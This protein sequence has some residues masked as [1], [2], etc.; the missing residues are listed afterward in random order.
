MLTFE[1]LP[2]LFAEQNTYTT[3]IDRHAIAD[4]LAI[5]FAQLTLEQFTAM[6]VN[7]VS[8]SMAY[9]NLFSGAQDGQNIS[10]LFN[11]HR[12]DTKTRSSPRSI[13]AA[14]QQ[15]A[16]CHGLAR[17]CLFKRG[18]VNDLLH[19]VLQLGI[20]GI[21]YVN[22]F[23][24]HK[25]R[26]IYK[27]YLRP[28]DTHVLDPCAGWGGRLLGA[29]CCVPRYDGFE[30]A[31]RTFAG[32][33][34]L[35]TFISSMHPSFTANLSMV[36]FED[37]KLD[38][39]SYDMAFTSP[40]YYDTEEYSDEPTQSRIRYTTPYAWRDG[41][42]VALIQKTMRALRPGGR[43][44]LNIGSKTYPLATW[45]QEIATPTYRLTLLP[46]WM[47]GNAGFGKEANGEQFFLLEHW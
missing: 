47:S 45:L 21:Q 33:E 43:F 38:D 39:Q 4:A 2:D 28:T 18:K 5:Q 37:A 20:N 6:L 40:P 16:F 30:P 41:F 15:P 35:A 12:L 27:E 24:A 32:L 17:A 19:Q 13:F 3:R 10:L 7:P 8:A 26:D 25:A 34:Q 31:S 42:F 22:D 14:L 11:P 29:S 44:I 36:P 23:P 46:I 1:T 9:V